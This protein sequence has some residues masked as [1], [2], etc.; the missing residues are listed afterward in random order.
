MWLFFTFVHI[1]TVAIAFQI[2]GLLGA[3]VTFIFPII[4]EI[5]WVI[6][7]WGENDFY[8]SCVIVSKVLGIVYLALTAIINKEI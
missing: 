3:I 8:V 2:F 6:Y 4:S 1:Y 5:F 7:M